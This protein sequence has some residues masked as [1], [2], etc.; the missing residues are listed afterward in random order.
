MT[1]ALTPYDTGERLEPRLW[2]RGGTLVGPYEGTSRGPA[3]DDDF[4][5]VDFE[6]DES[7]TVVTVYIER[8]GE[9]YT[10]HVDGAPEDLAIERGK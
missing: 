9:G 6:N 7:T 3:R 1:R 4:G 8:S 10:L 5:K 2:V